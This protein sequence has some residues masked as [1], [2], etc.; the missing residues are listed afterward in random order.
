MPSSRAVAVGLLAAV[1]GASAVAL[2]PRRQLCLGRDP[3]QGW[4][5]PEAGPGRRWLGQGCGSGAWRKV[6]A[7]RR[8]RPVPG[9]RSAARSTDQDQARTHAAQGAGRV[10]FV[11]A[12]D[13]GTPCIVPGHGVP[14]T[15]GAGE[16]RAAPT[17]RVGRPR[18]GRPRNRPTFFVRHQAPLSGGYGRPCP[19][20]H[21]SSAACARSPAWRGLPWP[22][23]FNFD[24]QCPAWVRISTNR[25][26]DGD[27]LQ[28]RFQGH[29]A[30]DIRGN[31]DLRPSS[32]T[33]PA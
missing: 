28:R 21:R 19:G 12:R 23:P 10:T 20:S 26:Q 25:P 6:A 17:Y 32:R 31:Q 30:Y 22:P 8:R 7:P 9:R 33:G 18:S 16:R 1:A 3:G 5:W 2:R 15:T 13:H 14:G 11:A 24:H 29:R 4:V 27:A